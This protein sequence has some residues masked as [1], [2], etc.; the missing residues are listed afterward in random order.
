MCTRYTH[1]LCCYMLGVQVSSANDT[2]AFL[3]VIDW[4]VCNRVAA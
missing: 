1:H 2:N 3:L 4:S